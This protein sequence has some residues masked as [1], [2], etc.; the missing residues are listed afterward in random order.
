MRAPHGARLQATLK[1]VADGI[2]TR[3]QLAG[4]KGWTSAVAAKALENARH[5]KLLEFSGEKLDGER[6]HRLTRQGQYKLGAFDTLQGPTKIDP[7]AGDLAA[8]IAHAALELLHDCPAGMDSQVLAEEIGARPESIEQALEPH[9]LAKTL[10]RY[11]V[12][13][14]INGQARR[15]M[16]YRESAG[17]GPRQDFVLRPDPKAMMQPRWTDHVKVALHEAADKAAA[18]GAAADDQAEAEVS[19]TLPPA[20]PE[21][22]PGALPV[23]G[24][25]DIDGV[26]RKAAAAAGRADP[27]EAFNCAL[28]S[29]GHMVIRSRGHELRLEP[30]HTQALVD[31]LA[32]VSST[33]LAA[34]RA[35]GAA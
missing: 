18:A 4:H 16:L 14:V 15:F 17:L 24:T 20:E 1:A 35:R 21:A 12:T 22:Q 29:N 5:F 26:D 6:A 34:W 11:E 28:W 10:S 19:C 33:D 8:R 2:V 23:V 9:V 30:E 31:Y 3:G 25:L 32:C 7:S 27:A 13:K